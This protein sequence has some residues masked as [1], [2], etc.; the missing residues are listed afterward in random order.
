MLNL[1]E[2]NTSERVPSS[3]KGTKYKSGWSGCLFGISEKRSDNEI[4][5]LFRLVLGMNLSINKLD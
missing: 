2:S 5:A 1:L 3:A 4:G